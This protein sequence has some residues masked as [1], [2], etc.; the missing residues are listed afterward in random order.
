MLDHPPVLCQSVSSGFLRKDVID[1]ALPHAIN[2]YQLDRTFNNKDWGKATGCGTKFGR[3]RELIRHGEWQINTWRAACRLSRL[4]DLL[5]FVEDYISKVLSTSV[6]FFW[7]VIIT[8][9]LLTALFF[10]IKSRHPM[11]GFK[12]NQCLLDKC[13]FPRRK[14]IFSIS[15]GWVCLARS[16]TVSRCLMYPLDVLSRKA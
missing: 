6:Y 12:H 5:K 4:F 16:C 7:P 2:F 14:R 13:T 10:S 3:W 9:G 11:F 15:S 8:N 1:F